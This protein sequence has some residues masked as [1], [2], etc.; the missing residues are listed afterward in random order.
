MKVMLVNAPPD[1]FQLLGEDIS[2]Q[3]VKSGA[4]DLVHL[5]AIK[6]AVLREEFSRLISEMPS[7]T[8]IWISWYKK[9]SRLPTDIN[10]DLIRDIVLPLDWVD[11]K[12][13]SVSEQW[14]GL[15]IVKR[16]AAR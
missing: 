5:F 3:V 12:V 15:K 13:C 8:I 16:K 7:N 6:A 11:I 1:Y 2:G 10:E 4:A 14:S 9:A